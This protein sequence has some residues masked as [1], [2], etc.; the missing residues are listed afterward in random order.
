MGEIY[1]G[2]DKYKKAEEEFKE[3]IKL[4]LYY[5][6]A[7]YNLGLIYQAQHKTKE[8]IEEYKKVLE[9]DKNFTEAKDK[10]NSL[11]IK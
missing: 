6:D 9:L 11:G 4:N 3:E 1:Y 5:P 7:K 10:L 8:A 2:L